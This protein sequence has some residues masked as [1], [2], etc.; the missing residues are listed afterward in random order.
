MC[1]ASPPDK[2]DVLASQYRSIPTALFPQALSRLPMKRRSATSGALPAGIDTP[3]SQTV[4]TT[5]LPLYRYLTNN[6]SADG[7]PAIFGSFPVRVDVLWSEGH[8]S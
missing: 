6:V 2:A 5:P 1:S 4:F 3:S 8:L 7:C